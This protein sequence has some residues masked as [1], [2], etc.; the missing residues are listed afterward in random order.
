M[1]GYTVQGETIQTQVSQPQEGLPMSG[2]DLG[3]LGGMAAVLLVF[4]LL[5]RRL[6]QA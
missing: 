2:A 1:T 6:T 3:P 4:G 5:L